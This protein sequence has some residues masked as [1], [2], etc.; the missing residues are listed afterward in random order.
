[1]TALNYY[2]TILP[3]IQDL[4]E[5]IVSNRSLDTDKHSTTTIEFINPVT[6]STDRVIFEGR[7]PN[8]IEGIYYV[9]DYSN[10]KINE[11]LIMENL[12][13]LYDFILIEDKIDPVI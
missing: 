5:N 11:E 10:N 12:E 9:A 6:S 3:F 2:N 13:D 1:M 4:D 7:D 8:T